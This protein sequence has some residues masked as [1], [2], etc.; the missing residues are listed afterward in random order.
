MITDAERQVMA[1]DVRKTVKA[2]SEV[3]FDPDVIVSLNASLA[4][5]KISSIY[6]RHGNILQKALAVAIGK[7][8]NWSAWNEIILQHPNYKKASSRLHCSI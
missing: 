2:L 4:T 5:S 8:P 1:K 7:N 6:K 3:D